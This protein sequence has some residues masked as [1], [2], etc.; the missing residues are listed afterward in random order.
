[1][2][3]TQTSAPLACEH[4]PSERELLLALAG[5]DRGVADELVERT[6]AR[7]FATLHRLSG[8]DRELAADLT[9]EA[10]RRAWAALATFNGRSRFSTWLFRIAY[11]TFLNHVRRPLR[12]VAVAEQPYDAADPAP[13][14]EEAAG[15]GEAAERVRRAVLDL[16]ED[17]RLT[18]AARYWGE[19]PV[20]E[21]AGVVGI[22]EV[23]VRKRL[24][25][26]LAVLEDAL[27]VLS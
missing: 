4:E 27:E 24:R 19:L 8:G 9:Q 20:R 17:L 23:A 26:A 18:V 10:Y 21:I 25:K 1:M 11:N 16:P 3:P 15:H 5:G 7:T 13:G 22:S 2:M 14:P 12:V 6:Y